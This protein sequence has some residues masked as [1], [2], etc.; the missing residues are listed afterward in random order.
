M[1]RLSVEACYVYTF[2]LLHLT[3][4]G[5]PGDFLGLGRLDLFLAHRKLAFGKWVWSVLILKYLRLLTFALSLW[6]AYRL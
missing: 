1:K 3:N 2:F 4:A 6:N 5:T